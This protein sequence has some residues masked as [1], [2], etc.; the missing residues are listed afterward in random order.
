MEKNKRQV[1]RL[2]FPGFNDAW[3]QRKLGEVLQEEKRP[4]TLID[5]YNYELLTVKRRNAGIVETAGCY[6]C[7]D[8]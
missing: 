1:P 8:Q 3:E 2:R 5:E 6:Y 7:C 4:I